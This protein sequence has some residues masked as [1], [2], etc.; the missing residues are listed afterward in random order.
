MNPLPPLRTSRIAS[1]SG[2]FATPLP[3]QLSSAITVALAVPGLTTVARALLN[4]LLQIRLLDLPS[5]REFLAR[6]AG[7]LTSLTTAERVGGAL[8]HAGLLTAYQ[9]GRVVSGRTF[10]LVLGSYR[11]L[12]RIGGGTVGVVFL[13]EHVLLRRRVAMKVLPVD[14]TVPADL[15]ER[16]QAETRVLAGLDNPHVVTAFDAGVLQSPGGVEPALYYLV[17]ELVPGGDLEQ[18]VYANGSQPIARTCE[19][20]RQAAA[21]LQA[22]HDRHL[23]HR[24]LKP[25]NLLL[26]ADLQVKLVDF[27]LARHLASSITSPGSLIGSIDFM[28]PEQ[29]LDA[30]AVGPAADIYGLGATLFWVLTGHLPVARGQ[31]PAETVRTLN[32]ATARKATL[33][34]KDV[35]PEL[36]RL[37]SRMLARDPAARP[38]AIEVM[39]ALTPFAI[40]EPT[41]VPTP[42]TGSEAIRLR[43]TVRQLGG[44]LRAKDDDVRKA[45]D[46]ILFA[47]AKMAES[48]DG[49]T[50]GHLHRMQEYVRLLAEQLEAHP[51]WAILTDRAYLEELIRCVPLHDIGKI[52]IPDAVLNKPGA[53]EPAEWKLVHSHP[54]IGATMLEALAREH[55]DSLTFLRLGHAIVRHHHERWDGAGYPDQLVGKAI[56]HS[57][58]LVALAD[59]YDSLRRDR[60][61]RPGLAHPE[62]AQAIA[63]SRGQFDPTVLAAFQ[64]VA[65]Q[66][67]EV[68]AT[69]PN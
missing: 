60:P 9:Q 45:Q 41:D 46:A 30:S 7:K 24:D 13:G 52:A 14:D 1:Q 68:Y 69:I 12:D 53:L 6:Q 4:E 36:E 44:T 58:R 63:A 40:D 37:L 31:N 42:G 8:M 55:G 48:H 66:F 27:G 39:Q 25:S 23:V 50:D 33:F 5:V 21:G 11:V 49:E 17:L 20:G 22:A 10:G 64:V 29:G 35:P 59:V 38:T 56:P 54:A 67:E 26:T 34:R 61:H 62:A 3:G 15:I 18:Y 43:E 32:T 16:F 51:D 19:W 47:M 2:S 28:P 57:A 65:K